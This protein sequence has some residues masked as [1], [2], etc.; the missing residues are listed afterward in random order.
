MTTG[1]P[2]FHQQIP[3]DDSTNTPIADK[4]MSGGAGAGAGIGAGAAAGGVGGLSGG[5]L[6]NSL[7]NFGGGASGD[8]EGGDARDGLTGQSELSLPTVP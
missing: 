2:R 3:Q 8:Y 6:D 4:F 1:I 5:K 7:D